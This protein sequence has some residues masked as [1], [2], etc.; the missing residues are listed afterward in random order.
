MSILK[1]LTIDADGPAGIVNF[2]AA[3]LPTVPVYETSHYAC[4]PLI[5]ATRNVDLAFAFGEAVGNEG[6]IGNERGD[7]TPYSGWYA[8]GVNIHRSQF[9]G[10]TGEYF[11]EDGFLTGMLAAYQ[12]QG[13]KSKGVYTQVKHF[14]VN[15]Q[16]TSRAGVCTWLN[17]QALR[18]IYLR[19]F[20][21][22]VKIGKTTGM[23]SSFNRIGTK[24]AGG[25]YRL[26]T[27]VLRGEWGFR[28]MVISDF[29]TG[30]HMNSKQMAY[31]GGD[32]NLQT[33]LQEWNASK[34]NPTDLAVLR[35]CAKNVL[36]TVVN[37][38]AMNDE[39]LGYLLPWWV[40]IMLIIV[41][42]IAAGLAVWGV[43]AVRKSVKKQRDGATGTKAVTT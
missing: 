28:G 35:Q 20:E 22:A 16:E 9:G 37:S 13:A 23:M 43:F 27:T 18:E 6:L 4:E 7:G 15:E 11:S 14:A 3:D 30:S 40:I 2:M 24:W 10:R 32:L 17:E 25:D 1:P 42:V 31:A 41:G 38:N 26:L 12:I 39:L 8:P 33:A 29:N 5:A 34:S 36:Y 21:M 19:P